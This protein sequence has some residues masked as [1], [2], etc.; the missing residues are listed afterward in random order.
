MNE[1]VRRVQVALL[2]AGFPPGPI[3]G[4][5]GPRTKKALKDWQYAHHLPMTGG[6]NPPSLVALLPA[7]SAAK[8][9]A[10]WLTEAKRLIGLRETPGPGNTPEIMDWA[11][12]LRDP[13][14]GDDAPWCGLFVAHCLKVGAPK[15]I[16]PIHPLMARS[17]LTFGKMAEPRVGALLVFWRSKPSGGQGHVGFCVGVRPGGFAL[18]GG[19]QGDRVSVVG[20]PKSRLLGARWPAGFPVV[21]LPAY[22]GGVAGGG[23]ES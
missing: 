13:Y 21:D 15:E 7:T 23:K 8:D 12:A 9:P 1:Q 2:A 10:P 14:P 3:D 19:N 16:Q 4:D 11:K 6:L 5:L 17:W 22:G 20:M 18:L